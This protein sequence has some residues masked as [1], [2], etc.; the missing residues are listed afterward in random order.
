MYKRYFIFGLLIFSIFGIFAWIQ[1][2]NGDIEHA[3]YS[4]ISGVLFGILSFTAVVYK[5]EKWSRFKQ[6]AVHFLVIQFTAFPFLLMNS[7]PLNGIGEVAILWIQ[8]NLIGI[9]VILFSRLF[10][11]FLNKFS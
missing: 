5:I 3:W 10:G 4:V 9:G 11:Y 8:F 6:F 1:F 7:L 2:S